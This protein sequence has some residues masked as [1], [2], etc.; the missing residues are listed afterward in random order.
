MR[1]DQQSTVHCLTKSCQCSIFQKMWLMSNGSSSS[2]TNTIHT[3]VGDIS[4][5]GQFLEWNG[6]KE[7]LDVWPSPKAN[8]I[9][10]TE[11]VFF[12]PNL[13]FGDPLT[14]FVGDLMR[15]FELQNTAVVNHL[16]MDA[17]RYRFHSSIF[18]GAFTN[19]GSAQ[20]ESWCPDGLFYL[21]PLK[22]PKVPL[23]GSK[24]HFLGGASSLLD[25]VDGLNP[26]WQQ[27]D[28]HIDVEPNLGVN[29]DFSMQI[30]LNVRVNTSAHF[31][32]VYNTTWRM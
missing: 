29:V 16:G 18:E 21:G 19:P 14:L 32:Y 8:H 30:Q 12:K 15:A 5:I 25:G 4:S 24:P 11:G 28:S 13:E 26:S 7:Y 9:H 20:W 2:G 23:Y 6:H 3:G 10:G 22:D 31:R 1:Y 17:L 27:H